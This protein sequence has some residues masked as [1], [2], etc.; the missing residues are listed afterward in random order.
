[1]FVAPLSHVSAYPTQHD[2]VIPSS[3]LEQT[4]NS[5]GIPTTKVALRQDFDFSFQGVPVW[6]FSNKSYLPTTHTYSVFTD[7]EIPPIVP[8]K[9]FLSLSLPPLSLLMDQSFSVYPA[10]TDLLAKTASY[11]YGHGGTP[12]EF[13][14]LVE[15]GLDKC[16]FMGEWWQEFY[17]K[18][19]EERTRWR[20]VRE[21]MGRGKCRVVIRWQEV[22]GALGAGRNGLRAVS[23]GT[24]VGTQLGF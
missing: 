1:M 18:M 17:I 21:S 8:S 6:E 19:A 23:A 4:V 20:R 13:A 14:E 22:N 12:E 5:R 7:P 10:G 24:G 11:F 2:T 16:V 9:N 15:Q 3:L